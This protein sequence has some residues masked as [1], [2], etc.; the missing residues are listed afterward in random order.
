MSRNEDEAWSDVM[1]RL[2]FTGLT[3]RLIRGAAHRDRPYQ[4]AGRGGASGRRR[5][6]GW[7]AARHCQATHSEGLIRLGPARP[8]HTFASDS[9]PGRLAVFLLLPPSGAFR[10]AGPRP[11]RGAPTA[12]ADPPAI[13]R[14]PRPDTFPSLTPRSDWRRAGKIRLSYPPLPRDTSVL[15]ARV[16]VA[17]RP[18]K[19][20]GAAKGLEMPSSLRSLRPADEGVTEGEENTWICAIPLPPHPVRSARQRGGAVC[21]GRRQRWPEAWSRARGG[22]GRGTL[23]RKQ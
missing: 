13:R 15:S 14:P 20:A 19:G 12:P 4:V 8:R 1:W 9:I 7:P 18:G 5:L 21:S 16:V 11:P 10:P 2:G 22:W 17:C 6:K 23:L 3:R